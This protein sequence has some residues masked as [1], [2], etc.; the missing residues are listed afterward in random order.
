MVDAEA[1]AY[2]DE[3]MANE[4]HRVDPD[5]IGVA[6]KCDFCVDRVDAGV[7]KGLVPGVDPAATPMCVQSCISGAL[8][9]GDVDD[10]DS[11]VSRLLAE[12]QSFRMHEDLGTG[13]G[14]HYLWDKGAL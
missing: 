14:F 8:H 9:F 6:I 12:N 11:D 7:A 5:R 13:P 3:A 2:G 10:P 4:R 1:F